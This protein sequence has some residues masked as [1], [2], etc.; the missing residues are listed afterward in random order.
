MLISFPTKLVKL[1]KVRNQ[2]E[3][4]SPTGHK[5]ETRKMGPRPES[6]PGDAK[7]EKDTI[8]DD[9]KELL[10]YVYIFAFTVQPYLRK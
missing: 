1:Y 4:P 10:N 9:A 3:L 8:V 5:V 6:Q 2:K 7:L